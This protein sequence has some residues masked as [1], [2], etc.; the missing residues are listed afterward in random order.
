MNKETE[1]KML[2]GMAIIAS[3]EGAAILYRGI[4]CMETQHSVFDIESHILIPMGII[5]C[6]LRFNEAVNGKQCRKG[7]LAV[8]VLMILVA[9]IGFAASIATNQLE[10][11]P[12]SFGAMVALIGLLFYD[13]TTSN[14]TI[15]F[16][17]F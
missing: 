2:N 12:Y 1:R 5:A 16:E 10:D 7:C 8:Y 11:V 17:D 9:V 3:I 14:K 4:L 15:R 6:I 13:V